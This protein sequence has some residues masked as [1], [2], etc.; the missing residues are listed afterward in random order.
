MAITG[1]LLRLG[2]ER[3]VPGG[4]G[5]GRCDGRAVFVPLS[6]PGDD[7]EV[8]V[9]DDRPG[10]LRARIAR[11]IAPGPGRVEPV[12]PHYGECGGCNMMHMS[13]EAQ[14]EAKLGVVRDAWRRSGGIYDAGIAAAADDGAFGAGGL[15]AVASV[16]FGYRNRAQFHVDAS[17]R[18]GYARRS[19]RSI[20]PV[21]SCPILAP[22]LARWLEGAGPDGAPPLLPAGFER[23]VAFGQG[24]RTWLEGID[25]EVALGIDGGNGV[26]TL[27]F[28]VGGFFQSNLAMVERLV[29]AVCGGVGGRR[30]ADLYCG[31]GL[32]GAFLAGA[33]DKLTCV[34]QDKR[35][36]GYACANVGPGASY[37][38]ASL[39]TWTRSAQARERFDYVVVDP[40][41][42]RAWLA[43][44]KAPAIGY[45]SCDPVSL[46][47]DSGA[48]LKAGYTV[49]SATVF[50]FY[51]QTSHVETYVRFIL[52]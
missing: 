42:V 48:L 10:Y 4:D 35:A 40:P 41:P 45:V 46:A 9:V 19:S 12:C 43:A 33:F 51:P 29:P 30:A 15:G 18:V 38:A 21:G 25:G 1:D 24:E 34:E 11:V 44:S 17:G 8:R 16:P 27:R 22:V 31:V 26:K 14:I 28:D 52:E 7:L 3:I 36:I 50:D 32:F 20:L 49:E 5:L 47:R 2:I 23:F 6:A 37:A 39:E 13:Y